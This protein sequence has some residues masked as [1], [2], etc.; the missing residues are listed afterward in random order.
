MLPHLAYMSIK[1]VVTWGHDAS[2]LSKAYI[3]IL[4]PVSNYPKWVH[5]DKTLVTVR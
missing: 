4:V 5:A 1:A 3:W 2:P